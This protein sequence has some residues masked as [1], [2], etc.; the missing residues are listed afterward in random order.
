[1][2][3]EGIERR[4]IVLL[5]MVVVLPRHV[6]RSIMILR[7]I[8]MISATSRSGSTSLEFCRV[9]S[10]VCDRCCEYAPKGSP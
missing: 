5:G 2:A 10:E 1:M 7:M 4:R 9:T 3:Y 6:D 8:P